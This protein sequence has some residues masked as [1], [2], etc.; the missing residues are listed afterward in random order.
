MWLMEWWCGEMEWDC[1]ACSG[2][3]ETWSRFVAHVVVVWRHG[4]G[5]WRIAAVESEMESVSGACSGG[6]E[7]WSGSSGSCRG[8]L[9]EW[10][11]LYHACSGGL[12]RCK[13]FVVH[14]VVVRR[15]GTASCW[16]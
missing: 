1:G 10:M 15:Y 4:V 3:V 6:V 13:W 8:G 9:E 12:E 16:A 2:G 5:L 7:I 14:V 11:G